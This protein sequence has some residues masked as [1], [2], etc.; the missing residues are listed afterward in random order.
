MPWM[1][2]DL[3]LFESNISDTLGDLLFFLLRVLHHREYWR[4]WSWDMY[5]KTFLQYGVYII[6]CN[7][8]ARCAI[9]CGGGIKREHHNYPKEG[10]LLLLLGLFI[11]YY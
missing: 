11:L 5:R 2:R 7:I 1:T 6:F 8:I 4:E 3:L 9:K 10:E